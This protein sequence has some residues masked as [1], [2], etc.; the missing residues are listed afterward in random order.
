MLDHYL[1]NMSM[2]DR[3][4][5]E[6]LRLQKTDGSIDVLGI[7]PDIAKGFDE[8]SIGVTITQQMIEAYYTPE[9]KHYQN[10]ELLRRACLAMTWTIRRQHSDGSIDLLETNFH[11]SAASAFSVHELGPAYKVMR[12]FTHHTQYEEELETHVRQYLNG[13]ADAMVNLG[14][15]TPNHRWV[16]SAALAYCWRLLDRDDCRKHIDNFLREGVDCDENGEYTERS[17]G[18]YNI[19]CNRSLC[20]MARELDMPELIDHVRRNLRMVLTY[21]EPDNTLSTIN[22][23]RQDVGKAPN[24]SAYYCNFLQMA[25]ITG[26]SELAWVADD[27]LNTLMSQT[28]AATARP[29]RY[30]EQYSELLLN[31]SLRE[32][33]KE[34]K[35][36][37]PDLNYDC[38]YERSG[39]V[40]YRNDHFA[41]T[42][43]KDRPVFAKFQYR[44]HAAY[45]R[46]S[47]SF[48]ARGQFAAQELVCTDDG[49]EL[50]FHD[51]WGYKRPMPEKPAS[52]DWHSMDHSL[53]PNAAMQDF[54][55]T[56]RVHMSKS[57]M[58]LYINAS[59]CEHIPTKLE[60]VFEPRG[61]YITDSM[62]ARTQGGNYFFQKGDAKYVFDDHSGFEITGAFHEHHAGETLRG[63]IGVD[64]DNFFVAMTGFTPIDKTVCIS[65]MDV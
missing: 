16:I 23:R 39:V 29:M 22:S 57:G 38:F 45:L 5:D 7:V 12:K 13:A 46:L 25:L 32:R 27:M 41:V 51:R 31:P 62:E 43:V 8:P 20:I 18:I 2:L 11:D 55:M 10:S 49:Y 58:Q 30:F 59:G 63:T 1:S 28:P 34:I 47:G 21:I 33:M 15:H 50:K 40:R 36:Q 65:G 56:V 53:R 17:A 26:D 48:F 54:Y 14:F 42:L 3:G 24:W 64:I 37:A 9:S 61:H 19:I 35:P 52:S 60:L 6:L 44:S 4:V